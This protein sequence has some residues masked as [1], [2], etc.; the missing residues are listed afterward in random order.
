[1]ASF[2]DADSLLS[3][4]IVKQFLFSRFEYILEAALSPKTKV[5]YL[6]KGL[7]WYWGNGVGG[8]GGGGRRDGG[9]LK[10]RWFLE[11]EGGTV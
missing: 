5:T 9:I 2:I 8:R 6:D 4:L 11:I 10:N 3:V 7:K 1:M